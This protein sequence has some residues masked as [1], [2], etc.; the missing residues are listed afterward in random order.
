MWDIFL[1]CESQVMEP[2]MPEDK[3]VSLSVSSS[4]YCYY[5][6]WF[7]FIII[8][9]YYSSADE[10]TNYESWQEICWVTS[11]HHYFSLCKQDMRSSFTANWQS[12]G[13]K[14][15]AMCSCQPSGS[16]TWTRW[17]IVEGSELSSCCSA[18]RK[19]NPQ[20][21]AEKH[22]CWFIMHA[23]RPVSLQA[24]L[25]NLLRVPFLQN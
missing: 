12:Q 20:T 10:C 21:S 7:I 6:Y 18:E 19:I 15:T 11:D 23:G 14:T 5:Y 2:K 4:Y 13:A 9:G 25:H 22:L 1:R 8:Y 24:S 3:K 16:Q 17:V